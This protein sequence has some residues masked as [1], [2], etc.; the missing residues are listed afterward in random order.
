MT[1]R[2]ARQPAVARDERSRWRATSAEPGACASL[3][4]RDGELAYYTGA[5]AVA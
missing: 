5:G 3:L 2:S 4:F 1:A